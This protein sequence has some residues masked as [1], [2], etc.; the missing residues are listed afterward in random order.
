MEFSQSVRYDTSAALFARSQEN[1][2]YALDVKI[3]LITP[4]HGG[5]NRE[6]TQN[7]ELD[8]SFFPTLVFLEWGEV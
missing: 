5:L 4:R 7:E 3:W 8:R 2:V 1:V 6:R